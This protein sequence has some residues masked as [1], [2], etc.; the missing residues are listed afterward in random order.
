[1][2]S[3]LIIIKLISNILYFFLLLSLKFYLPYSY[4]TSQ[5]IPATSYFNFSNSCMCLVATAWES[6]S[7]ELKPKNF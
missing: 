6:R 7:R 1:M 4:S 5:L 2:F 3:Y